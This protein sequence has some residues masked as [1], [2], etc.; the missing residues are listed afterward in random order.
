MG[1]T[2]AARTHSTSLRASY[3]ALYLVGRS[4]LGTPIRGVRDN[5]VPS[6]CLTN[7]M[8]LVTFDKYEGGVHGCAGSCARTEHGR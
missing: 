3:D 2:Q 1:N 7:S 6:L 5:R 8:R 4:V